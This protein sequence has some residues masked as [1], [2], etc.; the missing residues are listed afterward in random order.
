MTTTSWR[1]CITRTT[2]DD[3]Y[4]FE[5]REVYFGS[6]GEL[7]WTRD[8]VAAAGETVAEVGLDLERMTEA[9]RLPILDI[10]A[11]PPVWLEA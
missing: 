4:W 10:S 9:L 8:D 6:D 5:V 7:S 1:Y 11:V 3:G 2:T